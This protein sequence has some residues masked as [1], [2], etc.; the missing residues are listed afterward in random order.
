V[1]WVGRLLDRLLGTRLGVVEHEPW[2]DTLNI[3]DWQVYRYHNS[4]PVPEGSYWDRA[5]FVHTGSRFKYEMCSW[6]VQRLEQLGT[7]W[8]TLEKMRQTCI[9][10]TGWPTTWHEYL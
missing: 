2:M 7:L 5:R 1:T 8:P 6:E 9:L 3:D 10:L 4:V